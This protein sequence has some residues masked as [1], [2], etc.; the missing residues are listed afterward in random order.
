MNILSSVT[1]SFN[2]PLKRFYTVLLKRLIGNF[3]KHQ[4]AY[5]QIDLALST[6]VLEL[7]DLELNVDALNDLAKGVPFAITSGYIGYLRIEF[8]WKGLLGLSNAHCKVAV[9]GIEFVMIPADEAK[10]SSSADLHSSILHQSLAA[11][12]PHDLSESLACLQEKF[13]ETYQRRE[14][15]NRPAPPPDPS[16]PQD[17]MADGVSIIAAHI[18]DLVARTEIAITNASLRLEHFRQ[19]QKKTVCVIRLPWLRYFDEAEPE[20]AKNSSSSTP[21]QDPVCSCT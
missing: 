2:A 17:R 18:E 11:M 8:P 16:S 19:D 3:L 14:K 1:S 20:D 13:P 21:K 10:T 15:M 7:R 9:D 4:L 6:G 12:D 5:D